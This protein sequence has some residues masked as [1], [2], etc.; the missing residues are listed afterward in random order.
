M[1]M[2]VSICDTES[3]MKVEKISE[4]MDF[5]ICNLLQGLDVQIVSRLE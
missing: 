2:T 3:K 1:L 4:F 5:K